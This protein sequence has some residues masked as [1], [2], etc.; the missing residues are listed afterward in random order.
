[1]RKQKNL[2]FLVKPSVDKLLKHGE[3][4]ETVKEILTTQH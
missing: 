2:V 1:M 3:I 4:I